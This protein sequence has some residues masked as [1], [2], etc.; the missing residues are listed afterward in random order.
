MGFADFL[1]DFKIRSYYQYLLYIGGLVLILA[2]FVEV[3]GI[4]NLAVIKVASLV[5]L[6]SSF[7]WIFESGVGHIGNY[8][9]ESSIHRGINT[10]P[11]HNIREEYNKKS[12]Y[13]AV[14]NIVVQ[15]ILWASFIYFVF[16]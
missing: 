13:L 10:M 14:T 11:P 4:D 15:T 2:L 12:F 6:T 8:W 16:K 3:K 1:K 9:Y 5:I 7:I